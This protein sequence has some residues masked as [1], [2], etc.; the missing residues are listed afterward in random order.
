M[1]KEPKM[2]M[3]DRVNFNADEAASMTE[4][5]FIDFHL[6]INHWG[7]MPEDA[8]R[9]KL[10]ML[11]KMLLKVSGVKQAENGNNGSGDGSALSGNKPDGGSVGDNKQ[12]SGGDTKSKSGSAQAGQG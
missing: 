6:P 7:E 8:Q 9:M 10:T 3:H 12:E 1:N 11:H 2:L 4:A 5:A